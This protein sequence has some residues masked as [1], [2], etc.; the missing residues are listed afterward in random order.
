MD[1]FSYIYLFLHS[2]QYSVGFLTYIMYETLGKMHQSRGDPCSLKLTKVSMRE[3]VRFKNLPGAQSGQLS[4]KASVCEICPGQPTHV[5]H[6]FAGGAKHGVKRSRETGR[7]ALLHT[8]LTH[9]RTSWG[10]EEGLDWNRIWRFD[11]HKRLSLDINYH[12]ETVFLPFPCFLR[13]TRKSRGCPR[14]YAKGGEG[15]SPT[16]A[17][18]RYHGRQK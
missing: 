5:L 13:V 15:V 9:S 11:Y 7:G 2:L 6:S 14:F 17:V 3:R 8:E 10:R 16:G 18:G 4:Y 12:I 1:T